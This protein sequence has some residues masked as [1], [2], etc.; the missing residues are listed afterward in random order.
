[1]G[2][3]RLRLPELT[4]LITPPPAPASRG[5][6]LASS[7]FTKK[8]PAVRK[9]RACIERVYHR[10]IPWRMRTYAY[11]VASITSRV[12]QQQR[13]ASITP[14]YH[15]MYVHGWPNRRPRQSEDKVYTSATGERICSCPFISKNLR[16]LSKQARYPGARN[17]SATAL[18]P[19]LDFVSPKLYFSHSSRLLT[20]DMGDSTVTGTNAFLGQAF[21]AT[22]NHQL[23]DVI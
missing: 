4:Q 2:K 10:L 17:C 8:H 3:E 21:G 23:H 19:C 15:F 7:G 16:E 6:T 14:E 1:M 11:W 22:L 12:S 5:T 18:L 20:V 13:I 9:I